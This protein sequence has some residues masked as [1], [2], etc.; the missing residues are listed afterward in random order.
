M[1]KSVQTRVLLIE[2]SIMN[3]Q[4][5]LSLLIALVSNT[6]L[7]QLGVLYNGGSQSNQSWGTGYWGAQQYCFGNQ[8]QK[9]NNSLG[10]Q[11]NDQINSQNGRLKNQTESIDIFDRVDQAQNNSK[12]Q[13][14]LQ[15]LSKKRLENELEVLERKLEKKFNSEIADFLL[16]THIEKMNQCQDYR[17]YPDYDCFSKNSGSRGL[18]QKTIC[19]GKEDVPDLLRQKWTLVD[20]S[21]YCQAFSKS[22]SGLIQT[23]I[24]SDESLYSKSHSALSVNECARALLSYRQKKIEIDKTQDEIEKLS[25]KSQESVREAQT[26]KTEGGCE[27]CARQGRQAVNEPSNRDWWSTI[28]QVAGGAGLLLYG[29]QLEKSNQEYKAQVGL[30]GGLRRKLEQLV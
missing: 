18:N 23:K 13:I 10:G 22:S 29:N 3:S 9:T 6:G 1:I 11:F 24:C 2:G 15:K 30:G 5:G 19:E 17:T 21:G 14:E 4:I 25:E 26:A 27:E 20:H 7:A 12:K 16:H 8:Q 28:G